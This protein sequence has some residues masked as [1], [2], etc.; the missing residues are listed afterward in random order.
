MARRTHLAGPALV[1]A[2]LLPLAP[3]A[4]QA[5]EVPA[6]AAAA[7]GPAEAPVRGELRLHRDTRSANPQGPL[8]AAHAL[9]PAI[10]VPAANADTVELGLRGTLRRGAVSLL[11]DAVAWR[12]RLDGTT[13]GAT[14][15]GA[16]RIN[17][18]NVSAER[19]AWA[20]SAGKKVL[21]WDVGYG[22]RPNDVVQQELRDVP[23]GQSYSKDSVKR[24][25]Q[26]PRPHVPPQK[27]RTG[28]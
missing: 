5:V 4:A 1:A 11:G 21:G 26:P 23:V 3:P 28:K 19:G 18:L 17:E 8:A 27:R 13:S 25:V 24:S 7:D 14:W 15:A 10:G 22:F 16:G 12:Q 9:A 20:V 2:L 6:E